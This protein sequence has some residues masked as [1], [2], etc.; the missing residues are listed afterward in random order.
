VVKKGQTIAVRYLGQVYRGK[1][2]FD[3]NYTGDLLSPQIGV[4]GVVPGWDK[5]LVGKRVGSEV[6]L[7]I[8]P[9]DGY[10]KAGSPNA[11][12]KGTDTLYFVVDILGA[13]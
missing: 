11:G 5:T 3:E 4:G 8:P 12:I 2:P 13:A 7:A 1:K 9:K 10:G 6:I